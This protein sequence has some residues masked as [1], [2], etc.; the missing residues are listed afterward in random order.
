MAGDPPGVVLLHLQFP[1]EHTKIGWYA[2]CACKL[3]E[4]GGIAVKECWSVALIV[5]TETEMNAVMVMYDH[6]VPMRIDG[7]PQQYY[8]A[9]FFRDGRR[10]RILAARQEQ[11][12]MTAA[13]TLATKISYTFHPRYL[14]MVGI[15][16][17][18]APKD[19]EEQLYGDVVVANTVWN[20]SFGKFVSASDGTVAFGS[21]GFKPRPVTLGVSPDI[22]PYVRAAMASPENQNHVHIGP[23]ASGS[24]VIANAEILDKQIHSQFRDTAALDMEAYAVAYAITQMPN[25]QPIPLVIKSVCDYAD[26]QKSDRYQ[27][28]AAYTSAEFAKLLYEKFL[29]MED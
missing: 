19:V 23:I 13:A 22:F 16:A 5:A 17:G 12:G 10:Y 26:S 27:K 1:A 29:P 28:F 11:M 21:V 4:M 25:P 24:S 20:Y 18:V 8:E 6:W 7:D 15:A 3:Q 14:I 9:C 2:L